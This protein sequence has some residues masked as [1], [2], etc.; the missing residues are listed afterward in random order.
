MQYEHAVLDFAEELLRHPYMAAEKIYKVLDRLNFP[1]T[2]L[3]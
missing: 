2:G 1:K 3:W